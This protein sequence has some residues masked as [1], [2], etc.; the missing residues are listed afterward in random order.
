MT[1]VKRGVFIVLAV[2]FVVLGASAFILLH[3]DTK[4]DELEGISLVLTE[5]SA[6]RTGVE[7]TVVNG[8]D[9][10]LT[11]GARYELQRRG[12]FGWEWVPRRLD[13]VWPLSL[14]V[15]WA[16]TSRVETA[17]WEYGWGFLRPG[18]YRLVKE[19]ELNGKGPYRLAV[20]FEIE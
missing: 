8:T 19:V 14:S 12:L 11:F 6:S 16:G 7:F 13:T 15:V 20:E 2:I 9:G 1:R 18:T 17:D 5:G 4:I 3:R 10:E